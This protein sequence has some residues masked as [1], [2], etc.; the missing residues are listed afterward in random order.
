MKWLAVEI[1]EDGQKDA[2]QEIEEESKCM[3][4]QSLPLT[5]TAWGGYWCL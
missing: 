3:Q 4:I 2:P 5:Q 1:K